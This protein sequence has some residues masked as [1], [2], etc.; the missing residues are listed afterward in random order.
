[1]SARSSANRI[2]PEKGCSEF[3]FG[4]YSVLAAPTLAVEPILEVSTGSGGS[5]RDLGDI[6]SVA[7]IGA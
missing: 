2:W 4:R 6:G 1:M 5:C 7:K 3:V